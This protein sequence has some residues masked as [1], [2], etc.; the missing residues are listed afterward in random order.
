MG[1][2]S[3]TECRIQGPAPKLHN[4]TTTFFTS[5]RQDRT[6][7]F[8]AE[9]VF[10]ALLTMTVGCGTII[11]AD[12]PEKAYGITMDD[13]LLPA[14]QLPAKPANGAWEASHKDLNPET[15]H[16]HPDGE[17]QGK[18]ALLF[19][20]QEARLR[21]WAGLVQ[22][23][24]RLDSPS[25]A[26]AEQSYAPYGRVIVDEENPYGPIV[27]MSLTEASLHGDSPALMCAGEGKNLERSCPFWQFRERFGAYLVDVD[28]SSNY[29]PQ[30]RLIPKEEFLAVVRAVDRHVKNVLK[31]RADPSA[32]LGGSSGGWMETSRS[33]TLPFQ[34]APG[35]PGRS[36]R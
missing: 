27:P 4:C 24:H 34:A 18:S 25:A 32:N 28:Y 6:V 12:P 9:I 19:E 31:D 35:P 15:D 36:S 23:V 8:R 11:A 13:L 26:K 10:V 33:S 3:R 7:H 17:P 16:L 1:R 5:V 14:E 22:R 29:D 21:K 20:D 30:H 2:A